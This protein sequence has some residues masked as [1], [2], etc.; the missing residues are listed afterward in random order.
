MDGPSPVCSWP[1][2]SVYATV[3]YFVLG[4]TAVTVPCA[5]PAY[6]DFASSLSIAV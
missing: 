4:S 3:T 1:R 6:P 2:L 5:G